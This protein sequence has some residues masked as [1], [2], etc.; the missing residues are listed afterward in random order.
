MR[1]GEHQLPNEE[2]KLHQGSTMNSISFPN[3]LKQTSSDKLSNEE[4]EEDESSNY[5]FSSIVE[6][7]IPFFQRKK[8]LLTHSSIVESFR[9]KESKLPSQK[10]QELEWNATNKQVFKTASFKPS[11]VPS[12]LKGMNLQKKEI[13]DYEKISEALKT[14]EEDLILFE[15][16]E[17]LLI[18]VEEKET[19]KPEQDEKFSTF[20]T[21]RE[22]DSLPKVKQGVLLQHIPTETSMEVL[23]SLEPLPGKQRRAMNRSLSW[24]M[25]QEQALQQ[26]PYLQKKEQLDTFKGPV[27]EVERKG[28]RYE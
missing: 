26:T 2:R 28:L 10:R 13:I 7:N 12:A 8:T 11:Q 14:C 22:V 16:T 21:S 4:H 1:R 25:E 15:T 9:E 5:R 20:L 17:T 24:I 6:E 18:S 19:V 23:A 3:Y 27:F